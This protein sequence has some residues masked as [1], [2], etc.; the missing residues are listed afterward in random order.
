MTTVAPDTI[1]PL[2]YGKT[3]LTLTLPGTLD[4]TILSPHDTAPAPD[5]LRAVQDA[6]ESVDWSRFANA[7]S[8]AIAINDKTRPVPHAY[9]LPPLLDKL[10]R[11]G[12]PSDHITLMVATGSHPPMNPAEFPDILPAEIISRYRVISHDIDAP[13]ALVSLGTTP[14]GTP[15][16]VNRAY[17]EADLRIAVGNVEPHQFMGF[18]GGVKSAVIGLAGL[19]TINGNH[20]MMTYPQAELGR[21]EGNPARKDVED[22]GRIV[23]V[24]LALNTVLNRQK[25]IVQVYCGDPL[26]VMQAAIPLARQVYQVPVDQP[27]DLVIASPGGYPKDINVY[28]AQKALAHAALVTKPGGAIIVVAACTEGSGSA[29]YENWMAQVNSHE[30]VIEQF[31]Q[32]GYH[33]GPH[34]AYQIARDTVGRHVIWISDLPH[35]ARLLL[36]CAPTLDAALARVLDSS[37]KRIGVMPYANATIG[38]L[39]PAQ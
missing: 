26:E 16:T 34:K 6:V 9:L 31:T 30:A 27:F 35:P 37:I 22:M 15:V 17:M 18:S 14:A 25:Q 10:Q 19:A 8:A 39:T 7:T 5:P 20:Q 29:K 21:Y 13:D 1:I 12:I 2:P 11:I 33:V 3:S 32:E 23:G 24:H 38:M 36:E 28:Q 4:V